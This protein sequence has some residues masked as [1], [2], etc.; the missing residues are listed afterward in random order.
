MT[1]RDRGAVILRRDKVTTAVPN[2]FR[3]VPLSS[4]GVERAA[5]TTT[6]V[7]CSVLCWHDEPCNMRRCFLQ[8][9]VVRRSRHNSCRCAARIRQY[10][11]TTITTFHIF[12]RYVNFLARLT[13]TFRVCY[14]LTYT[15][16]CCRKNGIQAT[17]RVR[18][19][20]NSLE[21]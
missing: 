7:W 17:L 1:S 6:A 13:I 3:G 18:V 21:Y 20:S 5:V 2:S 4:L 14:N 16:F 10:T 19:R 9:A 11:V 15:S 12:R 8:V